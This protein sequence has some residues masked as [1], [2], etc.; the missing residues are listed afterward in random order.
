MTKLTIAQ[1]TAAARY[2]RSKITQHSSPDVN[3]WQ[4]D[5]A[6]KNFGY[7]IPSTAYADGDD[8]RTQ[9]NLAA[10]IRRYAVKISSETVTH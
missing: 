4:T 7:C 1:S 5:E 8:L 9:T 3:G 10:W 6:L 2:I